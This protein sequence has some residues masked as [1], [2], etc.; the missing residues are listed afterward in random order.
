MVVIGGFTI[1]S[2]PCGPR[3]QWDSGRDI[4]VDD[5]DAIVLGGVFGSASGAV[6]G[7]WGVE[8]VEAEEF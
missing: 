8:V 5:L 6:G 7:V 4:G 1:F 2:G 3:S